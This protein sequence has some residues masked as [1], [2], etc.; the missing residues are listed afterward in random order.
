M[1]TEEALTAI[2]EN[3]IHWKTTDCSEVCLQISEQLPTEALTEALSQEAVAETGVGESLSGDQEDLVLPHRQLL[4]AV[5]G[6]SE[7]P[8]GY[9]LWAYMVDDQLRHCMEAG[10]YLPAN[11]AAFFSTEYE[12]TV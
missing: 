8:S 2:R 11:V 5:H 3:P 4:D 1:T 6:L 12:D 7:G 10:A 9:L